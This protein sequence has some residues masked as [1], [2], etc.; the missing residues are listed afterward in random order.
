MILMS[1]GKVVPRLAST[2]VATTM[3]R[4]RYCG[5]LFCSDPNIWLK[6]RCASTPLPCVR[7]LERKFWWARWRTT[8]KSS[9]NVWD[10]MLPPYDVFHDG[11][12]MLIS[13]PGHSPGHQNMLVRLPKTGA[14]LLTGD[15]V[16]TKANWD[17]HK[18]PSRNFNVPQSLA[19]LDRMAAV[20]KENNAQ[21]WIGHETSEVPL[22]KYSPA[23][24][25]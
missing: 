22:R 2:V 8:S 12:V 23:Y 3:C 20:L 24:Y 21:L 10:S 11:S 1:C 19:S 4:A 7:A 6:F 25:E 18:V 9:L 17:G 14:I 16:H 13:T 15:S 5:I